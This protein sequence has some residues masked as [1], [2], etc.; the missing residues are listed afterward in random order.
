MLQSR[1][2]LPCSLQLRVGVAVRLV[3][4]NLK[5]RADRIRCESQTDQTK[6]A[7]LPALSIDR[8]AAPFHAVRNRGALSGVQ[9]LSLQLRREH[10][11]FRLADARS[12]APGPQG[13]GQ[14]A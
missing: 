10:H 4:G 9:T 8:F 3:L 1:R 2:S 11:D 14:D 12:R 13:R 7:R 6:P 5:S